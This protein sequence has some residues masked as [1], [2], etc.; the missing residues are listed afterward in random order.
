MSRSE[1]TAE[2][3]QW[4]ILPYGL[5]TME[6]V[7]NQDTIWNATVQGP[8][9]WRYYYMAQNKGIKGPQTVAAQIVS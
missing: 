4:P 5:K 7:S 1:I 6:M 8:L 2:G 9:K 3:V